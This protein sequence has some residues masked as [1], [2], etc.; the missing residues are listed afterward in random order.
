[1]LVTLRSRQ[2][3]R[4][5]RDHL[6]ILS[7]LHPADA[8]AASKTRIRLFVRLRI[9]RIEYVFGVDV[10]PAR[11]AVLPPFF[12]EFSVLVEDLNPAI[13][14]VA[15]EQSALGI[16]GQRVRSIELTRA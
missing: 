9:G 16:E 7:V 2:C 14:A 6:A 13:G 12:Q 11:T 10:Y 5:E 3:I 8:D 1:M 15:N 4:N